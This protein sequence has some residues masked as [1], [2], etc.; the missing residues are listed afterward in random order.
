MDLVNKKASFDYELLETYQAG[1]IL[2]G[3][4]VKSFFNNGAQ[5]S[6]GFVMINS[7][8]LFLN[9]LTIKPIKTSKYDHQDPFR[10]KKLLL[11]NSQIDRLIGKVKEKGLTIVLESIVVVN[12]KIKANICLAKGKTKYDKRHDEKVKSQRNEIKNFV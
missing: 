5:I 7:S 12:G 6:S 9:G 4:E 2:E 10:T 1:I 3:W 11:T 8:N